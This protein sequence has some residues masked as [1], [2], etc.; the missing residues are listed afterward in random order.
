MK[1]RSLLKWLGLSAGAASLPGVA[2]AASNSAAGLRKDARRALR[3]VHLTDIHIHDKDDAPAKFA[4][5]LAAVQSLRRKPDLILDGG[6]TIMD[7]LGQDK[8]SVEKQ[9]QVRHSIMRL[10]GEIPVRHC[11]GNHDIWAAGPKTDPLFG[12]QFALDRMELEKPYY[13]FD[14]KGWHFVILDSCELLDGGGYIGRFD[15]EQLEWLEADLAA[16][17]PQTPVLIMSHIPIL[18][19]SGFYPENARD[20]GRWSVPGSWMHIDFNRV[21][22]IFLKSPN[23]KVCL[24]G[25]MHLLD[26]VVYNDVTYLC[27]GAVCGNWWGG[28]T[29]HETSAGFAVLD[30]HTDGSFEREYVTYDWG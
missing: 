13:S 27:N 11:I 25:H 5:C 16:L 3:I 15:E 1:R 19:A 21:K 9:W 8:L 10:D 18:T 2:S 26:H 23:P 6:D 17:A 14:A 7:A 30:L 24:S 29:Y 22:D 12:K 28:P 4:R 20:N